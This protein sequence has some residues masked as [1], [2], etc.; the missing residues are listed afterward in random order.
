M[1]NLFKKTQKNP[2]K[3][4]ILGLG[5][6]G[7]RHLE[8]LQDRF[9]FDLYAFRHDELCVPSCVDE[10]FSWERVDEIQ[11]DVAIIANPTE[12]HIRTAW[13]CAI[14]GMA[15]FLEKPIG[16]NLNGL[17]TLINEVIK[18]NL[19][20]YVA[21]P[22]R[23]HPVIQR[24]R[25]I[26]LDGLTAPKIVAKSDAS[27]WP[28]KRKLN[29]VVLE[30]SHEL[31]YAEYLFGKVVSIKG[32]CSDNNAWLLV[33]HKTNI[34]SSIQLDINSREEERY[35]RVGGSHYTIDKNDDMYLKQLRYFFDNLD[36]PR[37]MNN[38]VEAS[39]LFRKMIKFVEEK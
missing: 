38:L 36:N 11:P 3:A 22:L 34:L 4:M 24:A 1:L 18:Q 9:D 15:I 14:R 30:L 32:R 26:K 10:V 5:S 13:Q 6:I 28:S 7:Q 23:F 25:K 17:D 21:Y 39:G 8:I 37:M 35:F 27:N 12:Y 19:T 31:D 29:N 33:R 16:T 2:K 20:T